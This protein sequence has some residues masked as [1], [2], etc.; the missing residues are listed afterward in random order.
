MKELILKLEGWRP[1]SDKEV[2]TG[3]RI[4]IKE[5][6][7]QEEFNYGLQDMFVAIFEQENACSEEAEE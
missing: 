4:E 2:T 1:W 6:M 3:C 5:N 7:T